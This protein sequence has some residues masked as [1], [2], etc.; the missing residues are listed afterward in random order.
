MKIKAVLLPNET[1]EHALCD[2]RNGN[3]KRATT[4]QKLICRAAAAL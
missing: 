2:C 3:S 1:M 4:P